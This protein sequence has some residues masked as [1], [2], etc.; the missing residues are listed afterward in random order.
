[1]NLT[2][3]Y[4]YIVL[5]ALKQQ[6]PLP[7]WDDTVD[8]LD[9]LLINKASSDKTFWKIHWQILIAACICKFNLSKLLKDYERFLIYCDLPLYFPCSPSICPQ[10]HFDIL[11][12]R[13]QS[14]LNC[15]HRHPMYT[16]KII[17]NLLLLCTYL[18]KVILSSSTYIFVYRLLFMCIFYSWRHVS[19]I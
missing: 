15:G 18:V 4:I 8:I 9:I 1:M 2:P 14:C 10:K 16:P 7:S 17:H 11:P 6:H 12:A 5:F 3:E 13:W 19:T